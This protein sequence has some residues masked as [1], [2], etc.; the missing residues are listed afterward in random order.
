MLGYVMVG[1]NNFDR[2]AE[3]YDKILA[4]LGAKRTM[5]NGDFI[6]WGT[7]D[8]STAFSITK[9]NDGNAATVGNGVM[10]AFAAPDHATVDKVHAMALEMGGTCEGAP[11]PRPEFD[12][13]FYV[14]YFRD[15][16]GNKMNIFNY[17]MP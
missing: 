13:K 16:D 3:F 14:G 11:G 8:V 10:M 9:P 7:D 1:T 4:E 6:V 15:L 2:A 12:E 5:G 17:P